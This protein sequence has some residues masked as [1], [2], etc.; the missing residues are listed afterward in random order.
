MEK[1][2]CIHFSIYKTISV[3]A[4]RIND[5][6]LTTNNVLYKIGRIDK[7]TC[8]ICKSTEESIIH[9]L[10]DLWWDCP[11]TQALIESFWNI[12]DKKGLSI[13]FEKKTT[14]FI[15]WIFHTEEL[16][17]IF[18]LSSLICIEKR[19][20]QYV[21][22]ISIQELLIDITTHLTALKYNATQQI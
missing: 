18:Y 22:N 1:Y 15:F 17:I 9:L 13:I 8:G 14:S 21:Y 10:W 19:C 5:Y 11:K 16:Y 6:I 12:C 4:I 2:I 7:N 3:V 20:L